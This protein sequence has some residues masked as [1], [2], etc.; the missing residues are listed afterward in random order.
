M[1]A[2]A[3]T[4]TLHTMGIMDPWPDAAGHLI[5]EVSPSPAGGQEPV[6]SLIPVSAQCPVPGPLAFGAGWEGATEAG[7]EVRWALEQARLSDLLWGRAADPQG[8]ACSASRMWLRG[9]F[10]PGSDSHLPERQLVEVCM[11]AGA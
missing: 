2:S 8:P 3:V 9:S 1:C 7:G 4:P 6:L 5:K 11:H 10:S